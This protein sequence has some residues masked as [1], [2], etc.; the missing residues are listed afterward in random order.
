MTQELSICCVYINKRE[1]HHVDLAVVHE[2]AVG[3]AP[4]QDTGAVA[5]YC[6]GALVLQRS[7]VDHV[8]AACDVECVVAKVK[9]VCVHVQ[10]QACR[11]LVLHRAA[12]VI[13]IT[14]ESRGPWVEVRCWHERHVE[15]EVSRNHRDSSVCT[16][17]RA[18][19]CGFG[20]GGARGRLRVHTK[21]RRE[22]AAHAAVIRVGHV[23]DVTTVR[24]AVQD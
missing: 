10:G 17:A 14:K 22:E 11:V 19:H 7:R 9:L 5:F 20:P 15:L 2:H 1:C 4:S 6:E 8:H 12:C 24:A 23:E 21:L 18:I 16:P 3:M 13:E